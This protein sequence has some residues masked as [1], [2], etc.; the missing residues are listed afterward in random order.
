MADELTAAEMLEMA[1]LLHRFGDDWHPGRTTGRTLYRGEGPDDSVGRMD[2]PEAAR[3]VT[4][5]VRF[6]GYCIRNAMGRLEVTTAAERVTIHDILQRPPASVGT[7]WDRLADARLG[8][9]RRIAGAPDVA[10]EFEGRDRQT[11]A[12]EQASS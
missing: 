11:R 6:T 8:E 5:A 12:D 1:S 9:D 2:T 7:G 10:P 4:L 3:L